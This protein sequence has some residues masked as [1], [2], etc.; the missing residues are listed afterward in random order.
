MAFNP[1]DDLT[2]IQN[3]LA[4]DDMLLD[5]MDL[6]NSKISGRVQDIMDS[7]PVISLE[8]ARRVVIFGHIIKRSKWDD[9]AGSEKRLCI[10]FVPDRPM[11]NEAFRN[12]TIEVN[13]HVP[14]SHDYKAW[15]VLSKINTLLHKQKINN[16]YLYLQG[17][18]GELSTMQGFFCCGARFN[19]SRLI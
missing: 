5:L 19:F 18:L 1:G 11:K 10:Y 2:A 9:L 15:Q 4:G 6:S 7:N 8:D 16:R 12:S 17:Q 3:I 14:A 13:I